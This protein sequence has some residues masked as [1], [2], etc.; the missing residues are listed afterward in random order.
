VA[1]RNNRLIIFSVVALLTGIIYILAAVLNIS[2]VFV[3]G[4]NLLL[5]YIGLMSATQYDPKPYVKYAAAAGTI[6][7]LFIVVQNILD[8]LGWYS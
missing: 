8:I 2:I 6:I 3:I 7:F 4:L 5:V 1:L